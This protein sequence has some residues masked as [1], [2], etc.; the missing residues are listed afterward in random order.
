MISMSKIILSIGGMSCSACSSGLEKYLN[1]QEGIISASVNLV[2]AQA[3]IEYEDS[4]TIEKL[5]EYIKEAGFESLGVYDEQKELKK[6]K[7]LSFLIIFG[8]LAL[9]VLYISMAPMFKLPTI[10]YVDMHKNPINYALCLFFLTVIFIIYGNDIFKSG[11]KNALHRTS[12]MDTLVSIGVVASFGYSLFNMVMVLIGNDVMYYIDNLYFES[13]A[14]IIYFIKLGRYIDNRSKEKTKEAL[15]ELVQITPTSALLKRNDTEVEVTIDEIKKDDILICKPGMKVAVDGVVVEGNTHVNQSFITGEAKPIKRKIN[16]K[17][18]AGSVNLDGY[19]EYRAQKIGKN[20]TIS[21]IVKLV[22]EATNTKAPIQRIADKVSGYFVPSI[23]AIA[24]VTL[25]VYLLCGYTFSQSIMTFVTVLVVA[26][27]CALGLATPLAIVVSEG[28]CAKNGILVKNSKTLENAHKVDTLIF[29]KTGTLT[30]GNLKI[31]KIFNYSKYS[32][33]DL[34]KRV[35][36]IES[37]TSHPI[38]KAFDSYVQEHNLTLSDVKSFKNISGMGLQGK[39]DNKTLYIGNDKLFKKLKIENSKKKDELYLS[40]LGNSIIYVIEESKIIGL[41]GVQD[42]VRDN[43]KE[44]ITKLKKLD[45][46]II[47]LTGDGQNIANI[48][49]DSLGIKNVIADVMPQDKT[50]VVKK[51]LAEGKTVMMIGDGINDAPALAS[52]SI[53]VSIND[54]TDI[55]ADSSDVILINN[56]LEKIISL[57]HI[58]KKT[59]INIKQNL[60]WA[61]FYNCCMLPIAIGLLKPFGINMNPMIAGLAMTLSSLTVI[62]NALRLKR[63]K[64]KSSN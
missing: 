26:C 61:F 1:K 9:V 23:I 44:T 34:I 19:I 38:A 42:I 45:K 7:S 13:C 54:A 50:K 2:L 41:I 53:G 3:F 40:Q 62:L 12:N 63:I 24:I 25:I 8:V 5:E 11:L 20:S 48:I 27:P 29:D 32:D 28:L 30:Y 37:K 4:I 56:D 21:E 51:L 59:V 55:A 46:D 60:F 58:S 64:I 31:F 14:I 16:D 35:A 47:M 39:I 6:D 49:A 22:V 52:A 18:I 36:S 33:K 17:V 15:K 43:A 57:I 10:P